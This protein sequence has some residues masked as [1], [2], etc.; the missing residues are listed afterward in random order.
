MSSGT[1][2]K[3]PAGDREST[4]LPITA[5][6]AAWIIVAALFVITGWRVG[7][8]QGIRMMLSVDSSSVTSFIMVF[9][10]IGLLYDCWSMNSLNHERMNVRRALPFLKAGQELP[11][12]LRKSQ[13]ARHVQA[14]RAKYVPM[15]SGR[16]DQASLIGTMEARWATRI[17]FVNVATVVIVAMGLLGTVVGLAMAFSGISA[18]LNTKS[19]DVGFLDGVRQAMS[20]IETAFYATIVGTA[21][22]SVVLVILHHITKG[23]AQKLICEISDATDVYVLPFLEKSPEASSAELMLVLQQ[24]IPQLGQTLGSLR[25]LTGDHLNGFR[26][27]QQRQL[28]AY[29]DSSARFADRLGTLNDVM[30]EVLNRVADLSAAVAAS[31]QAVTEGTQQVRQVAGTEVRSA[32][33][34]FLFGDDGVK[35]TLDRHEA[36]RTE[37]VTANMERMAGILRDHLA[38]IPASGAP[39][40]LQ[41]PPEVLDFLTAIAGHT[42][43]LPDLLRVASTTDSRLAR[44]SQGPIT[45]ALTAG[46]PQDPDTTGGDA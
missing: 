31:R 33:E 2:T 4:S 29:G 9:F 23:A 15:V 30:S 10:Y 35:Q 18:S 25:D 20:G 36:Q 8:F 32:I 19:M 42:G 12:S 37:A 14:L 22:G 38:A 7:A 26:E 6:F 24:S 1:K 43:T 16:V 3:K 39:A 28:G 44:F 5:D 34:A 21:F 11:A 41:L 13:I 45:L 17:S 40:A 27:L 46:S